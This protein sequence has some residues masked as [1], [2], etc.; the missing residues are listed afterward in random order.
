MF[1]T[2]KI[3]HELTTDQG[4]YQVIDMTYDGRPARILFNGEHSAAQSGIPRDGNP[5]MLFD[6]NRRFYELATGLKPEKLL[7]IGGGTY[8]LPM[9]LL[10]AMPQVLIDVVEP[11]IALD[12]VA[13]EYFDF[14]SN[15]RLRIFHTDG[16]SFL[17]QYND[18]YDMIIIDAFTVTTIPRS[19]STIQAAQQLSLHLTTHGAVAINLISTYHGHN[20]TVLRQ[21]CAAYQIAFKHIEIFPANNT[22]SPW[23][24]Q[25]FILV[26]EKAGSVA[27]LMRFSPIK[28]PVI[29]PDDALFD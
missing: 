8:T 18:T 14:T 28:P 5:D 2:E 26:G 10:S 1:R 9:A 16:R 15:K 21:Q 24:S 7:L 4:H 19:L 6:Y 3:L 23:I 20:T 22:L 27:K 29:T 17:E 25:N 13:K 11:E 12:A